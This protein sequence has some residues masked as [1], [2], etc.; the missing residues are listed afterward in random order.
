MRRATE[1]EMAPPVGH[2]DPHARTEHPAAEPRVG[3]GKERQ[4]HAIPVR[5][6]AHGLTALYGVLNEG[7]AALGRELG[8]GR[9]GAGP[10]PDG[11]RTT[12]AT[13]GVAWPRHALELLGG[14]ERRVHHGAVGDNH[15]VGRRRAP[16]ASRIVSRT[17][18]PPRRP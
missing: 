1:V 17:R 12:E 4:A 18:R 6:A 15:Q 8:V 2:D 9:H 7:D 3:L 10:R 13:P 16:P 14:L 11:I 5:D